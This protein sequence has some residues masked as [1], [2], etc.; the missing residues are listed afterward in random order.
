MN[1]F[2]SPERVGTKRWA[3]PMLGESSVLWTAF[4]CS[5]AEPKLGEGRSR[6]KTNASDE[7]HET[8]SLAGSCSEPRGVC[9]AR[10]LSTHSFSPIGRGPTP[11]LQTLHA[12]PSFK[13][14]PWGQTNSPCLSAAH[15]HWSRQLH[16]KQREVEQTSLASR[17]PA[18]YLFP[19]IA[20][21]PWDIFIAA[22]QAFSV[23]KDCKENFKALACV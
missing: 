14:L 23:L 15:L 13:A 18:I 9:Q 8:L 11:A 21:E 22:T 6:D 5:L 7:A 2:F 20:A 1:Y 10:F 17:L 12:D 19:K 4:S 16:W 3:V